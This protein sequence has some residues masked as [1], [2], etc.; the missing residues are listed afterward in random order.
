MGL[1]PDLTRKRPF[2]FEDEAWHPIEDQYSTAEWPEKTRAAVEEWIGDYLHW[3]KIDVYR[4][5]LPVIAFTPDM[6]CW[7]DERHRLT[8]TKVIAAA[9][10]TRVFSGTFG[11]PRGRP[12][13]SSKLSLTLLAS[14]VYAIAR[15][16]GLKGRKAEDFTHDVITAARGH[17]GSD[18]SVDLAVKAA[19]FDYRRRL[20]LK[21]Q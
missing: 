14:G 12:H 18:A 20:V 9:R 7:T 3:E 4:R 1:P 19:T 16:A 11:K 6:L 5:K 8:S 21:I 17:G 10:M 13:S 15:D 2:R